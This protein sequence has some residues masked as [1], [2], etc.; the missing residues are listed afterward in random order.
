MHLLMTEF[1]GPELTCAVDRSL[2]SCELLNRI[3]PVR[4]FFLPI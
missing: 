2:K 1:D 3:V 4:F